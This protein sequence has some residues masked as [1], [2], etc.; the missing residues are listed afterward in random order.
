MTN[1]IIGPLCSGVKRFTRDDSY[2]LV[3]RIN[4]AFVV[5]EHAV[6]IKPEPLVATQSMAVVHPYF[7]VAV[8]QRVHAQFGGYGTN[9]RGRVDF[10]GCESNRW[11]PKNPTLI[12]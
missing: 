6:S 8:T 2:F 7:T 10:K 3:G 11:C 9:L 4:A 5:E 1:L 12:I